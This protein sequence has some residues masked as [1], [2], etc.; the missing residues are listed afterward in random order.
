MKYILNEKKKLKEEY[1]FSFIKNT[2]DL[3]NINLYQQKKKDRTLLVENSNS[4]INIK[5]VSPLKSFK[6]KI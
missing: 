3:K 5:S 2:N 1:P 6:I 4:N